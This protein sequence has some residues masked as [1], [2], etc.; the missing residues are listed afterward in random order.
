MER[1]D[2]IDMMTAWGDGIFFLNDTFNFSIPFPFG[3]WI[4]LDG[5]RC[6]RWKQS[7]T[8]LVLFWCLCCWN[9][10]DSCCWSPLFCCWHHRCCVL[11]TLFSG[12][13]PPTVPPCHHATKPQGCAIYSRQHFG[14]LQT[15][16]QR[17]PWRPGSGWGSV[18]WV[19]GTRP[20]WESNVG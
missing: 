20:P 5:R 6:W 9:L 8:R 16:R 12:S 13:Q 15:V 17:G 18:P 19:K 1:M 2:G 7:D 11:Y 10:N 4:N 14:V 3:I